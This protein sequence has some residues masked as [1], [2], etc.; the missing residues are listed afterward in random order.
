[1][2]FK[3]GLN[4]KFFLTVGGAALLALGILGFIGII[5]PTPGQSIFGSL[6]WFDNGEN[7]A[8]TVLGVAGLA[9]LW[10]LTPKLQTYLVG[11]LGVLGVVVGLYSG[12]ISTALLGSNLESPADTLLHL[13][14]GGW[15][16]LTFYTEWK[17]M[18]KS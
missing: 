16:L 7:I 18:A 13:V 11:A 14:V 10:L 6:W 12:V 15:A 8:H 4:S 17:G 2:N 5:G 9:S 1:M 3:V